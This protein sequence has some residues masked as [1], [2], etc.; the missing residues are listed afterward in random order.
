[1]AKNMDLA[2]AMAAPYL[3]GFAI[4]AGAALLSK[5][6]QVC[7]ERSEDFYLQKKRMAAFFLGNHL[8]LAKGHLMAAMIGAE[9][10]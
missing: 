10:V 6:A 4:I 1:M 7:G 5:S 3:K 2:A 9:R 8:T